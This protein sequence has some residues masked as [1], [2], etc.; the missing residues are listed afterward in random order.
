M[1]HP[2][3]CGSLD[4]REPELGV[5]GK[6]QREHGRCSRANNVYVGAQG[7]WGAVRLAL[8]FLMIKKLPG[9]EVLCAP[10]LPQE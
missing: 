9:W 6:L 3:P 8:S 5:V 10:A 1:P 4:W 7:N 2:Q